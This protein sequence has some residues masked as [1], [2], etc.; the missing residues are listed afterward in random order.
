MAKLGENDLKAIMQFALISLVILPVLPNR[1]Y[2]PYAVINPRNIWWMVVLI[3]GIQLAGYACYK[4]FG[5]RAGLLLGGLLGGAISSTA[6]VAS[7][8]RRTRE[9]PEMA[10]NSM[11]VI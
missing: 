11:I 2:L 4:L 5:Q 8:A 3:V 9:Q 7:Y 1:T 10:R 6:T